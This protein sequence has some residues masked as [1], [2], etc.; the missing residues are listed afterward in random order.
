MS[1]TVSEKKVY[2]G[3]D[4]FKLIASILVII[5]H[6]IE[7]NSWY[8]SEIKFVFT[9]LAVPFFFIT[10]GF[11]FHQG[12]NNA[13]NK[14]DYFQKYEK[15]LMKLF[16]IWALLIYLPF[17]I[18]SYVEKYP[19]ASVGK[20]CLYL[21]RRIFVIGP[22]PYW[23]LI[24]LMWSAAFLYFCNVK[25]KNG[26]IYSGII[27]GLILEVLYACFR[28]VLQDNNIFNC[29]FS[30]IY[31]IYSWEF[32]FIMFGIPFM[33]IGYI[34]SDKD[35]FCKTRNALVVLILATVGRIVEYNMSFLFPGE[36]WKENVLSIAFIVQAV[37]YFMLAQSIDLKI[38]RESSLCIRQLSS[39]IYF[40]HAIFLYEFLNP[41]LKSVGMKDVYAD[42]L[43]FFKVLLTLFICVLIFYVIKK[44]DNRYLNILING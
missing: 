33:G 12:I 35:Y 16:F 25:R 4:V 3:L 2:N 9:R 5:L 8:P 13:T 42:Y 20:L 15:K 7:T 11:F 34:I 31:F 39:F 32:N 19:T 26:L 41:F 28:G 18:I 10:S 37:A 43:I 44:I 23:Y 36:F 24:A 17:E 30:G 1:K 27:I 38:K 29:I 14:F 21:F 22:G 6:A 40:F